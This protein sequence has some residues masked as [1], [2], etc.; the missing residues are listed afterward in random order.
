MSTNNE[1]AALGLL[2]LGTTRLLTRY[3]LLGALAASWA[4]RVD[5]GIGTMGVGMSET[6]LELIINPDFVTGITIDE[7]VGVLH[8]EC[9]HVVF[10][11]IFMNPDDFP[12]DHALVVAQETVVNENMKE[13][14][15]G[16]PIVLADYPQLK[17]DEDTET[18]YARLARA[19]SPK[20]K[21]S[22]L[23]KPSDSPASARNPEAGGSGPASD[24]RQ[25]PSH[26]YWKEIRAQESMAKASI[27]A[28][29]QNALASTKS[30]SAYDKCVIS[31]VSN[32][33]GSN[34]GEWISPL[35]ISG[36]SGKLNWR[37]LLRQFVGQVLDR[38][39]SYAVPPRRFPH[40]VGIVPGSRRAPMKTKVAAVIDTSGSMSD[41]ML[42]EISKELA[43]LSRT[44]DVMV[45]ECDC[46]IHRVYE[47]KKP[48]TDVAGR[49]GTSFFPPLER[50]FLRKIHADVM[51]FFTDGYGPAPAKKPQIPVLWA[52]TEGGKCPATW[53]KVIYMGEKLI[54]ESQI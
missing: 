21:S 51:I 31:E 45:V 30:L 35:E 11:H 32:V 15:P 37:T 22:K 49:G 29:I 42:A 39:L 12:D 23:G 5:P 16:K 24:A 50:V 26:G 18:R 34:P 52:L 7:L 9:R 40:L 36:T 13:P 19:K 47:Y 6:G 38:E 14:L 28:A 54:L 3:P 2:K 43:R 17:P 8:H 53:G 44:C 20:Q 1:R 27:A 48:I 4:V 10:N 25:Q 46:A 41:P 33:C